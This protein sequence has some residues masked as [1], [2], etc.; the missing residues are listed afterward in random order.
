MRELIRKLV[1]TYGPAGYEGRVRELIQSEIEGLA[2]EVRS[3]ALGN[4]IAIRHGSEE[5]QKLMLSA[6]MDEIGVIVSHVD[7]KGFCR[8][9]PMGG[10]RR[11]NLSGGRVLFENGTVGAISLEKLEDSSKVP[12][13]EKFYIDVGATSRDD[14]PVEVGDVACFLRPF[15][16]GGE[17]L[18]AKAF[19]DRI[20]CAVQI[21]VMREL[22]GKEIPHEVSFV[23]SVQ[24]EVGLRGAQTSAYGLDPDLGVAVDVTSTGDTPESATMAVELGKGP[25]IKVKDRGMI[26]HPAVKELLVRTAEE[27]DIPYQLEVLERGTTDARVIQTTRAGVPTGCLS[28]PCRYVHSPS[29]I[30]DYSDVLNAVKLLTALLSS[31]IELE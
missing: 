23:F 4:L 11:L 5:A 13:L 10:V 1:E 27:H 2:D 7:E 28:I 12:P 25:A 16:D 22:K 18:I 17:R 26:T 8:F 24:E 9:Q 21:G 30:V 20:G 19:D 15:E 6:H 29:E 14:C 31:P 3:D